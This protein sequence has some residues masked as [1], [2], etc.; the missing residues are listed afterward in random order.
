MPVSLIAKS[1]AA[2]PVETVSA[3]AFAARAAKEKGLA[4][5]LA[6]VE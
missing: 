3:K 5:G 4:A 6:G 1:S 2:I